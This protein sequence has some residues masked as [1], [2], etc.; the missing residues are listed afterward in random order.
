MQG[1]GNSINCRGVA[2]AQ[3]SNDNIP[4]DHELYK[5]VEYVVSSLGARFGKSSLVCQYITKTQD[6][7]HDIKP[8]VLVI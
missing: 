7:M 6:F 3:I 5:H 8:S 1:V 4:T 2:R